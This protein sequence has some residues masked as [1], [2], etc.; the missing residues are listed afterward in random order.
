MTVNTLNTAPVAIA[1]LAVIALILIAA[2]VLFVKI[3]NSDNDSEKND[4]RTDR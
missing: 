1:A 3:V 2:G 4:P